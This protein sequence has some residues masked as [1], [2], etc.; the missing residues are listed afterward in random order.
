MTDDN[1]L[2]TRAILRLEG[3][4]ALCEERSKHID[5][6]MEALEDKIEEVKTELSEQ[7]S[8]VKEDVKDLHGQMNKMLWA[9]ILGLSGMITTVIIDRMLS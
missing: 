6:R 4:E 8:D 9:L 2:A 5:N 3:H 1:S 7:I